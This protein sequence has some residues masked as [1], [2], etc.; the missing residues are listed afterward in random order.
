M[1]TTTD[2][3]ARGTITHHMPRQRIHHVRHNP[4]RCQA[5]LVSVNKAI[6][7]DGDDDG[8]CFVYIFQTTYALVRAMR[9]FSMLMVLS[10]IRFL[11]SNGRPRPSARLP[12]PPHEYS[13]PDESTANEMSRP[14]ATPVMVTERDSAPALTYTATDD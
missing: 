1:S 12:P 11:G 9:R 8:C 13:A 7:S 2:V 5:S 4:V 6:W 14:A 3:D 10:L